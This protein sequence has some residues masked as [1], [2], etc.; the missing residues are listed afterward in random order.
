[1]GDSGGL[2]G[3][4]HETGC[5]CGEWLTPGHSSMPS[6]PSRHQCHLSP[7]QRVQ[8][9]LTAQPRCAEPVPEAWGAPIWAA[10]PQEPSSSGAAGREPGRQGAWQ[11]GCHVL[12]TRRQGGLEV[13]AASHLGVGTPALAFVSPV[14]FHPA[15]RSVPVTCR[16]PGI[17]SC[18]ARGH[19]VAAPTAAMPSTFP[20]A[21][22]HPPRR[23]HPSL[24]ATESR[25]P[26]PGVPAL[27]NPGSGA[28]S[29]SRWLQAGCGQA[30]GRC[31]VFRALAPLRGSSSRA[32]LLKGNTRLSQPPARSP[33]LGWVP[34][35]PSPAHRAQA[36]AS[37][38]SRMLYARCLP[39]L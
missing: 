38:G 3:P 28:K 19:R 20:G 1:M 26:T 31:T 25:V 21:A 27:P 13:P 14:P 6:I 12:P 22:R 17:L 34:L 29:Y 10:Q 8:L 30:A 16:G 36:T 18:S 9:M 23:C 4:G 7:P 35:A 15:G 37:L 2:Q 24:P 11:A 5:S 39:H 33:E 32:C